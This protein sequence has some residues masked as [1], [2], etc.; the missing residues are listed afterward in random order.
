MIIPAIT[1]TM[2]TPYKEA[3]I[4]S[5]VELNLSAF[6]TSP[7][8]VMKL[9]HKVVVTIFKN[10]SNEVKC[11]MTNKDKNYTARNSAV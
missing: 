10:I 6:T 1:T 8:E 2:P 5:P 4:I 11:F 9:T 3:V 7:T